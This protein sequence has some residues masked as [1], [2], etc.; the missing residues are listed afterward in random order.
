MVGR[1]HMKETV[2]LL[3]VNSIQLSTLFDGI[4]WS[5]QRKRWVVKC[6]LYKMYR[7]YI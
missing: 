7:V 2:G 5:Y 6:K 1:G 4:S 3:H